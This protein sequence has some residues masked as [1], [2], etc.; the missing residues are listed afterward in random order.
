[1][2]V[3]P[4]SLPSPLIDLSSDG[5]TRFRCAMSCA[6][7]FCYDGASRSQSKLRY[8]GS[9]PMSP[10]H[11]CWLLAI[12][13]SLMPNHRVSG[14]PPA[15]KPPADAVPAGARYRLCGHD[16]FVYA[17]AFSP[18]GKTL[19]SASRDQTVRLWGRRHRQRT[20]LPHPAS[21]RGPLPCLRPGWQDARFRR[22]GRH[23]SPVGRRNRPATS[24][25]DGT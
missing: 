6:I 20:L 9:M 19:A 13:L 12:G 21:A 1:M 3:L 11:A 2:A 8:R 10:R 4:V 18:D 5:R 23:H 22:H 24:H 7:A 16:G 15:D 17:V 25:S 14:K